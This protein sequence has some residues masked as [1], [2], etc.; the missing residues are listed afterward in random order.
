M[1]Y[2]HGKRAVIT[3]GSAG[4][5]RALAEVLVGRKARVALVARGQE[6]LDQAAGELTDRGGDVLAISADVTDDAE[7]PRVAATVRERWGGVDIVCH[8]AGRSMRSLAVSTPVAQYRELLDLN[9]LSSVR[10]IQAFHD[11]LVE[12]RGHFVLLGSLAGKIAPRYYGAYPASKFAVS[13]LAQQLRLELGPKGLHVLLVCPGPIQRDVERRYEADNVPAEALSVG[14]G[15]KVRK[16]KPRRLS[17]RILRACERRQAE[18]IVPSEA[19]LLFA[20]SQLWPTLGD[21]ILRRSTPDA[22]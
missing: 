12:S 5:G 22:N 15:A 18:L 3:G 21:W 11:M 10:C 2:W 6:A 8:C 16:I 20:L 1:D 4:L 9:F 14:A 19:R 13:A 17:M 7:L